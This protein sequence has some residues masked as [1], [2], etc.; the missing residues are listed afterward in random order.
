VSNRSFATT[1]ELISFL[2][3]ERRKRERFGTRFVLV[4]GRNAWDDLIQTLIPE[5]GR[6]VR[7]SDFCSGHDT[8]PDMNRLVAYLEGE[9]A[10]CSSIL[11][12]PLAECI[13]LDPTA[14]RIIRTLAEWPA[15]RLERIYVPL[16]AA[17]ELFFPEIEHVPRY[18][19]GLLPELWSLAGEG[20]VEIT[21]APFYPSFETA[22]VVKGIKDYLNLWE[23]RSAREIW[24]VTDLAQWLPKRKTRSECRVR[25]YQSSFDYIRKQLRWEDIREEW[26]TP[27]Q[28]KWLA[29]QLQE[30]DNLDRLCARSLN[31]VGYQANQLFALW[32]GLDESRRWLVWLWSKARAA[33]GTYLHH[34]LANNDLI[35]NFNYAAVMGVFTLPRSAAI[36][37]ERKDLLHHLGVHVMP[38]DFWERYRELSD[39]VDRLAVLT[40]LSEDE[41][42]ELVRC[43]GELLV[44]NSREQWWE[45]LEVAWPELNWYLQPAG[46]G[47]DFADRYFPAYVSCRLKDRVDEE[48]AE[49][50]RGWANDQRLWSYRGR[51]D[52]LATERAAGATVLWVDAMGAE[53]TGLLTRLLTRQA[54]VECEIRIARGQLPTVTE[55]NKEWE[56]G[57]KVLR[58]LDDVAH[59]YDYQF[60]KSLLNEINA[61]KHVAAEALSL[62]EQFPEVVI[63]S[64]HGLSRFAAREGVK[65]DPP[66]GAQVDAR[67][68]YA[69]VPAGYEQNGDGPWVVR[70]GAVYL[71]TH[72][73]FRGG[74]THH[75]EVH[76]GATPEEYLVPIIIARKT[77]AKASPRFEVVTST[78]KLNPKGRGVL[79]LRCNRKV[80]DVELRA[81]GSILHGHSGSDFTWSFDLKGWKAGTYTGSVYVANRQVGEVSFEVVKGLVQEDLGL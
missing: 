16:F 42:A 15:E 23:Q 14:G 28:W 74:S 81:A 3:T 13:R 37:R 9:T 35:E 2:K 26:G 47:D 31:V 48:L 79:V 4:Q 57:E 49:L 51:S 1:D 54:E 22:T 27:D 30:H 76:G 25:L 72:D 33:A 19:E 56:T 50:I 43:V 75:G 41:Q 60:P 8:F 67:G 77:N 61:I 21:V 6:V 59:H 64:D 20:D 68:R 7:L 18:N 63:T 62:L 71:V 69:Q 38:A 32:Q 29:E 12:T 24:L 65:V 39:P 34:V 17:E 11:L 78:I 36:S 58:D 44:R 55:A 73:G 5:V 46:T 66:A 53:W 45:Y 52:Q 80:S 10:G 40:D 70:D